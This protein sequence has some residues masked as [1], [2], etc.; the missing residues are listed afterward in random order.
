MV[1]LYDVDTD[2]WSMLT[3]PPIDSGRGTFAALGPDGQVFVWGDLPYNPEDEEMT[4]PYDHGLAFDPASAQ[5]TEIAMIETSW[6][7]CS[8]NSAV[9]GR[10]VYLETCLDK[11]WFDPDAGTMTEI[12]WPPSLSS[13][14]VGSR[15][16]P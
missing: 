12:D 15:S 8:A 4:V 16:D 7:E 9:A 2:R 5:W 6:W 10:L 3:G 13:E 1:S 14:R 11:V